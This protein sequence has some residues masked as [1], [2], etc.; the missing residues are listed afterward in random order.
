L[1]ALEEV[2]YID[3]RF[4]TVFLATAKNPWLWSFP[5]TILMPG[6]NGRNGDDRT[7]GNGVRA[8]ALLERVLNLLSESPTRPGRATHDSLPN[9][10]PPVTR[11]S[12]SRFQLFT[13]DSSW[14]NEQLDLASVH[15]LINFALWPHIND[16][17]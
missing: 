17:D 12:W 9:S 5:R 14:A 11:Q 6:K 16:W 1:L 13:S 7:D 15:P 4:H 10:L 8:P 2:E 3:Q